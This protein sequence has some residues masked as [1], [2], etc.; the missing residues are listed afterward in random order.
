MNFDT[1]D[2]QLK[3]VLF[4]VK[5][6][7]VL[8]QT[9]VIDQINGLIDLG[10]N[11]QIVSFYEEKQKVPLQSLEKHN[12][13]ER[14]HFITPPNAQKVKKP[15]KQLFLCFF[16]IAV[17]TKYKKFQPIV[18]FAKYALSKGKIN[19]AYEVSITAWKNKDNSFEA[20]SI[21]AHFGNNGV[22]ANKFLSVGLLKGRLNTVFHG[23]EIS[24]YDNIAFWKEEYVE[25]SRNSQLLPISYFWKRRLESWGAQSNSISVLRMGVDT[26]KFAFV[27]RPTSKPVEIVSVARATEKKGLEY[28]IRAMVE[29]NDDY[30]LSIIGGGALENQLI[31]LSKELGVA[32]RVTFHGAKPPSFV[33]ATLDQSDIFLLPSV[34][35]S[36]G[37]MEGVHVALMEAMASGLVVVSTLHSGIPE[38]IENEKTGFLVPE[39]DSIAIST[40]IIKASSSNKLPSIRQNAREKVEQEFNSKTL[41]QDLLNLA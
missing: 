27:N 40:A 36:A 17:R 35:D 39:R 18:D 14:T 29:L 16:Y 1:R 23:Y 28:A 2:Y 8:S 22:V 10:A 15:F 11:V 30:H 37:D 13:L 4:F 32:S 21:I 5:K 3:T 38:L 41:A 9:F 19:L 26:N 25:L 6:F 34:T 20:D 12:L 24:E 7:P 33:K 31:A